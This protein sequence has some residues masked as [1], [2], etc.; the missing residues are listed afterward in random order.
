MK[1]RESAA[2]C[3][4]SQWAQIVQDRLDSGLSVRMY[5]EQE[6]FHESIYYYWQRKLREAVCEGLAIAQGGEPVLTQTKPVFAEVR[7]E[8]HASLPLKASDGQSHVCI[9]APGVRITAGSG[10]PAG[11]LAY[12]MREVM[13]P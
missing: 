11:N 5:C 3:R 8:S 13:R 12:L 7:L 4:L 1:T 2:E 10:Y 9:E 6:G